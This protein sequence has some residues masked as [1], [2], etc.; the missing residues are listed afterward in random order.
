M[1]WPFKELRK[2][3]LTNLLGYHLSQNLLTEIYL[4]QEAGDHGR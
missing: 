1:N 3:M 4:L 2:Q